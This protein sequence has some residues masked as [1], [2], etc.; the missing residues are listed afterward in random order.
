VSTVGLF[1]HGSALNGK[2]Q[3]QYN[4]DDVLHYLKMVYLLLT[5]MM[6]VSVSFTAGADP[7]SAESLRTMFQTLELDRYSSDIMKILEQQLAATVA[8]EKDL[9]KR[10]SKKHRQQLIVKKLRQE[11]DWK[12]IEPLAI[13]P[14]G[15]HL[16]EDDVQSMNNFLSSSV[17]KIYVKKYIP[18]SINGSTKVL[19]LTQ[20]RADLLY[21]ALINNTPLPIPM[22]VPDISKNPRA[23]TARKIINIL[24]RDK[25][26]KQISEISLSLEKNLQALGPF[27]NQLDKAGLD[28]FVAKYTEAFKRDAIFDA[29]MHPIV[30][31]LSTN[32]TENELNILLQAF[33][34]P[35]WQRLVTKIEVA[36]TEFEK[37]LN[38]HMKEHITPLI[39]KIAVDQ[40]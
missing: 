13:E 3:I 29:Y 17:G 6:G 26:E 20:E 1:R 36:N 19:K 4:E 14:Y 8:Q 22:S 2:I 39:M 37:L 27:Q 7:A 34:K 12:K 15:K 5:L 10:E 9:K 21:S 38:A 35:N 32:L 25:F 11:M 31:E 24:A 40:E 23:I 18:V 28:D 16:Q 33:S 30:N